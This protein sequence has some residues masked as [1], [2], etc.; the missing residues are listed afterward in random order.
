M[1]RQRDGVGEGGQRREKR[2]MLWEEDKRRGF[3]GRV[4][5]PLSRKQSAWSTAFLLHMGDTCI[6]SRKQPFLSWPFGVLLEIS[7]PTPG[8]SFT[9][10]RGKEAQNLRSWAAANLPPQIPWILKALTMFPFPRGEVLL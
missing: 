5:N 7:T 8:C 4:L 10:G 6:E 1:Y 2:R 3:D 9:S